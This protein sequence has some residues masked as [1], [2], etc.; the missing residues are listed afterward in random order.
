[1]TPI[2]SFEKNLG[3][4]FHLVKV[5]SLPGRSLSSYIVLESPIAITT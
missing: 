2:D 1:M 4:Q 5:D 3:K